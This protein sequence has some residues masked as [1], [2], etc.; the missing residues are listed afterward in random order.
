MDKGVANTKKL[1][2]CSVLWLHPKSLLCNCPHCILDMTSFGSAMRCRD[3]G[4]DS[5][6]YASTHVDATTG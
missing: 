6:R 5:V 1:C 4:C 2:D 3:Q